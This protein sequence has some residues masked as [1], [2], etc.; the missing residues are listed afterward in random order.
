[1]S[2]RPAT[3]DG[4]T[5]LV[6]GVVLFVLYAW[7][8]QGGG[9]NQNAR[10]DTVRALV[11][12]GS[13]DITD[14]AANTGD[15]RV[16]DGRVFSNKPPGMA[17][18]GVAPYALLHGIESVAG[19][20]SDH[21]HVVNANAHVLGFL[22]SG[23][24]A[25]LLVLL[26]HAHFRRTG[27]PPRRAL[28]LCLGFGAGTLFLPFAGALMSHNLI[29]F[30]LFAAW[31]CVSGDTLGPRHAALTG[32]ALGLAAVT[33]VLVIPL[34]VP[35]A[36][37]V[38]LRTRSTTCAGLFAVGPLLALGV[39]FG[40]TWF[41]YGALF[42]SSYEAQNP[43]FQTDGLLFGMIGLPQ[44][45]RLYW[46]SFHPFRGLF[47]TCPILISGLLGLPSAEQL[48][49]GVARSL[50]PLCIVGHFVLFNLCF[51]GWTGGWGVGPRYL[52]P[53]IP[54]LFLLAPVGVQRFPRLSVTLGAL[55]VA[56]MLIATSVLV[57]VPAPN[58]ELR[59]NNPVTTLVP[60][61]FNGEV[62]INTQSML[63]RVPSTGYDEV[64]ARMVQGT[65]ATGE[66]W[67]SYNLGELLG[68]RGLWSLLPLLGLLLPLGMHLRRIGAPP[69][70]AVP[71]GVAP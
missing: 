46:L 6:L 68:L 42:S 39:Y 69:G 1:M 32:A 33:E 22:L 59:P 49:Q 52:I 34:L 48:R 14:Y 23:L 5:R 66:A 56:L 10:F 60:F 71:G 70:A 43:A 27:V 54:F 25:L 24:P 11:E 45:I 4:R 44:P 53:I 12:H 67:D 38:W 29:A 41:A 31:V 26:L 17:L 2:L 40:F 20:D 30:L 3:G 35:F 61:F 8:F 64:W 50:L 19:L 47:Y 18:L 62:S 65:P 9:W 36:L 57:M 28:L 7:F 63:E 21:P 55:S 51:N 15:V 58:Q 13:A 37:A 16:R